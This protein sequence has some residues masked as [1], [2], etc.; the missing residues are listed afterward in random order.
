MPDHDFPEIVEWGSLAL[1]CYVIDHWDHTVKPCH[2]QRLEL[3]RSFVAL[4]TSG[5]VAYDKKAE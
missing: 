5:R 1:D 4:G 3:V 2:E